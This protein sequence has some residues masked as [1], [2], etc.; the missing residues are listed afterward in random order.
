MWEG[1]IKNNEHFLAIVELKILPMPIA[2][3]FG[4]KQ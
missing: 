4:C 1:W 2:G 3:C